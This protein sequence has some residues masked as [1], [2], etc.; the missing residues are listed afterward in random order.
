[1]SA[2]MQCI[3]N[4]YTGESWTMQNTRQE[5]S[6][7]RPID[8]CCGGFEADSQVNKVFNVYEIDGMAE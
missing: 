7:Q 3:Y 2:N 5:G 6:I 1:M 8:P 4:I